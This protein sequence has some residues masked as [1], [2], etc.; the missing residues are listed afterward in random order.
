MPG[1]AGVNHADYTADGRYM[2]VSCEFGGSMIVVDVARQRVVNS[3]PLQRGASRA[4]RGQAQRAR[5]RREELGRLDPAR[6]ERADGEGEQ[7]AA[8]IGRDRGVDEERDGA[9]RDDGGIAEADLAHRDGGMDARQPDD[10]A[11]DLGLKRLGGRIGFGLDQAQDSHR[12]HLLPGERRRRRGAR[13]GGHRGAR[14]GERKE[15]PKWARQRCA[16]TQSIPP[17]SPVPAPSLRRRA[18]GKCLG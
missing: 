2:L 3:I 15:R 12:L 17:I 7:A 18:S 13:A 14:K 8:L 1:C 9:R 11:A 5:R 16:L 4:R 6:A 10:G